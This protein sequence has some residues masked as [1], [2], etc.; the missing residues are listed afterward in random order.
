MLS[1]NSGDWR[2]S[3]EPQRCKEV[4]CAVWCSPWVK[5]KFIALELGHRCLCWK[6]G[7]IILTHVGTYVATAAVG[8]NGC[9][10]NNGPLCSTDIVTDVAKA[11]LEI[12][13]HYVQQILS[14]M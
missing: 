13:V 12:T 10:G 2:W 3:L 4:F 8:N 7:S 9:V 1:A 6:Q 11:V 14:Q 5:V